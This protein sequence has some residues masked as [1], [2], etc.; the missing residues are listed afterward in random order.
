MLL[1]HIVLLWGRTDYNI[2]DIIVFNANQRYPLI[3]RIVSISP[4]STKGDHNPDHLPQGIEENINSKDLVGKAV[5]K[6]PLLGWV[7]LIFFEWKK[8][9]EQRGLCR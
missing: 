7:K 4:L 6:I 3:H 2:G 8:P 1:N 9:S 5:G